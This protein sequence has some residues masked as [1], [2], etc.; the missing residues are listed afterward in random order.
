M[1]KQIVLGLL[2]LFSMI[3]EVA[4]AIVPDGS[5]ISDRDEAGCF[6][7]ATEQFVT[8]IYYDASDNVAVVKAIKSLRDDIAKVTGATPQLAVDGELPRYPIIIGTLGQSRIID[9]LADQG[10]VCRDSLAGRWETFT[11]SV[12]ESPLPEVERA[13]IIA[14]SDRRATIYGVYELSRQ[15]GVSPW[16]WWL[17]APVKQTTQLYV[18]PIRYCSGEPRVKYRGIFINDEF[19]SM[20]AWAKATFGGMNSDMYGH[21]YEL[22]LRLRANCMW[23]AMWGSFKEYKPLVPVFKD[24]NGYFEGNCF[25]EDDPLNPQVADEYGIV[26][27]TSHHEPMQRSQQEWI[28]HKDEYGNGQWN[29]LTNRK[30]VEKFFREGIERSKSFDKI[31]TMGMRGEE[32]CPMVDAGSLEANFKLMSD[33]ITRQRKIIEDVTS[34]PASAT[35]QV[36]TLY[37]EVLDYYD[38]GMPIP[39]DVILMFC[40]DNFGNVRRL[41]DKTGSQRPGGY[42]LYYH[43]SYY[44]APRA[45]KW[46]NT[47]QI[48]Y[49]W[50]QL[51]LTLEH[52]VDRMWILNVG[53]IKPHEFPIDFFMEMAWDPQQFAADSLL[54][55]TRRYCAGV[56]GDKYADEAAYLLD[57]YN[58]YASWVNPELL[59]RHTYTLQDG[60]YAYV[61]NCLLALEA[62]A[63]RLEEQLPLPI[64]SAY[65][66]LLGYPID[67]LANLY[68]LNF[69]LAS[70]YEKASVDDPSVDIWTEKVKYCYQRDSMLT[71]EYNYIMADGKWQHMMDQPHIG[72]TQWHAPQRNAMPSLPEGNSGIQRLGGYEF[73]GSGF[74]VIM[75]A[76]HFFSS[77]VADDK[78]LIVPNLGR[79]QSSMKI[80]DDRGGSLEYRYS[81][82]V[83][84]DSVYVTLILKSVMPFVK[85]GH[86]VDVAIDN[87]QATRIALNQNLNWE[88]KYDLMYPTGASRVIRST[89]KLPT[90][91]D[92]P[93][94]SLVI[95]PLQPGVMLQKI[96]VDAASSPN[97]HRVLLPESRYTRAASKGSDRAV[98]T[99]EN[100]HT[101]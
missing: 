53:D 12:A 63:K 70:A 29:Y 99:G 33:I 15:L 57:T 39:D 66:Q 44:G 79:W 42:G 2:V 37:S 87:L 30:G 98:L 48:Q 60:E 97:Q 73:H 90:R 72:Y 14:G 8:G 25:N 34:R 75:D 50:E 23:P 91:A 71:Y 93:M 38:G 5:W 45:C 3:Q 40:D 89:V 78:I 52:G 9:R 4:A 22:L 96:I 6:P 10:V 18:R 62:R 100:I 47:T 82:P 59:D 28:R 56:L 55:Y 11:V 1:V 76:A 85:G 101:Q 54:D 41:P 19:P 16:Y 68:E 94:H 27:G 20:T 35:P 43:V 24:G 81:M 84:A 7:I 49:M 32:D 46:L 13:L 86:Y 58:K 64:R 21:V 88:H 74:E 80:T 61:L 92:A 65:R 17:D 26:I 69:A 95:S 36:W 77:S 31:V 83:N 67:A 51:D